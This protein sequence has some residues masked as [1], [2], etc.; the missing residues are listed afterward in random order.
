MMR[1]IEQL[2]DFIESGPKGSLNL[3]SKNSEE[4]DY[5]D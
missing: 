4:D 2:I 5:D 3:E 1:L